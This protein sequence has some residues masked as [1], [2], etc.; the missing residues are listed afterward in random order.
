MNPY[1]IIGFIVALALAAGTG[2]YYG[3]DYA[4]AKCAEEKT[5]ALSD[6]IANAAASAKI[7]KRLAV[8]EA[9]K[10]QKVRVEFKDRI[11]KVEGELSANPS[12]RECRISDP[13]VGLFNDLIKRANDPAAKPEPKPMPTPTEPI[14]RPI[15][16]RSASLPAND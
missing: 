2:A 10:Q 13:A 9:K 12:P 16:H 3:R 6:A 14:K 11:V 5:D 1:L 7:D 15:G 8:E 4:Q